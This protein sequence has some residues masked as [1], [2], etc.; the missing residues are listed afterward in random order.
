MSYVWMI[1]AFLV[2]GLFV[3]LVF[4]RIILRNREKYRTILESGPLNLVFVVIYNALCYA[5]VGLRSD[6]HVI[7][8][9]PVFETAIVSQWYSVLGQLLCL[10]SGGVLIYTILKRRTIGGQDTGGL[11]TAGIYQFSRHPIYTGI[12]LISLGIALMRTNIDGMIVFPFVV[13]A[14]IIQAHLEEKYDVGVRFREQYDVYR[15]KTRMLGP[16]WFWVV[17]MLLL[18]IPLGIAAI[19]R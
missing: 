6:P 19:Q 7:V 14:N 12:I 18:F 5:A 10:A 2:V 9:P 15:K 17:L 1:R 8:K 13:F 11:L 3:Y 4:S 16:V